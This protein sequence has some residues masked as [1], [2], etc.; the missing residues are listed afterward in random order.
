M[1]AHAHGGGAHRQ[2]VSTTFW[3]GKTVTHFYCAPDGIRNSVH[4]IHW[5]SSPTIYQLSH[6]VPKSRISSVQYKT[7]TLHKRKI[8][9]HHLKVSPFGIALVKMADKVRRCWYH[10]W[11]RSGVSIPDLFFERMDKNTRKLKTPY[12]CIKANTSA[13]WQHMLHIPPTKV[14][15]S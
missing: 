11:F 12:K 5:I 2:R 6:H 13:I 15:L 1:R 14:L 8:Y 7:C 10:W 3:L 9:K 4:G